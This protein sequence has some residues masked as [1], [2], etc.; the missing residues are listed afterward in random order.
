MGGD[1]HKIIS[2]CPICH[3]AK[4]QF[5]QGLYTPLPVP[6][7]PCDDVGMDFIVAPP[8]I[9]SGMDVIMVVMDRFSKMAHFILRHKTDDAS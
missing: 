7:K 3:K 2:A 5:H 8:R 1:V 9:Q 6:L 4:G